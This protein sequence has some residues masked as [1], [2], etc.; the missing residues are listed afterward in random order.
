MMF[1][2]KMWGL[3]FSFIMFVM[4]S[5]KCY[6]DSWLDL[7]APHQ[8]VDLIVEIQ[9]A[10]NHYNVPAFLVAA[11]ITIESSGNPCAVNKYAVGLMQ[12]IPSTAKMLGVRDRFDPMQNLYGGVKYLA[13]A[14]RKSDG[15]PYLAA[16]YYN[17]GPANI[18]RDVSM[19]KK[20]TLVYVGKRLPKWLHLYRGEKWKKNFH[21]RFIKR[22]DRQS[23]EQKLRVNVK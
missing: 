1:E 16:A 13:E 22:T 20:E 7:I 15:N 5:F 4:A 17:G 21:P 10:A 3:V 23:C 18:N 14:L 8:T 12:I 11:I 2:S 6:S 9:R 19:W